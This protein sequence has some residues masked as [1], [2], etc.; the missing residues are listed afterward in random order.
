MSE[1][2]FEEWFQYGLQKSFCGP[3][4]CVEHDGFPT[5]EEEDE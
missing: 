1:M 3:P 5:T 2:T 4:L